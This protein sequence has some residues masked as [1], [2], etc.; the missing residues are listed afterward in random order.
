MWCW[1]EFNVA[2]KNAWRKIKPKTVKLTDLN[3]SKC[4]SVRM[5]TKN[6]PRK[7]LFALIELSTFDIYGC[8]S[9]LLR[10]IYICLFSKKNR[11]VCVI[12]KGKLIYKSIETKWLIIFYQKLPI[13][14][15]NLPVNVSNNEEI[16]FRF[17]PM[18]LKT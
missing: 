12:F 18:H 16:S 11:I 14:V 9:F 8:I 5:T 1:L 6:E 3:D 17:I 10:F 2:K 7:R 15:S 13:C 4:N